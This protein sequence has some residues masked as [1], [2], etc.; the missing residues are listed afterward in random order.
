[1]ETVPSVSAANESIHNTAGVV[2]DSDTSEK[3]Y[4]V[5]GIT[6]YMDNLMNL[7]VEN[8]D[9]NMSK[10]EI[11]DSFMYG[12]RIWKYG[13]TTLNTKLVPEPDNAYDKNAIK[14]IVDGEHIGYIKSGSCAHIHKL[15]SN[16]AVVDIES[17]IGGG[18][19]KYVE[20]DDDGDSYTMEKDESPYSCKLT[21]TER[22]C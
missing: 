22:K 17:T 14:V 5:A 12:E 1:M 7:A 11:V 4:R 6:H 9:Y 13:F 8:E 19:Y 3:T 2:S 20:E 16:N 18:P 10:K 21:I 15:L